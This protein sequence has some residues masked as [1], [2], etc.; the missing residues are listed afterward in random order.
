MVISN[1]FYTALQL[2]T[3]AHETERNTKWTF[4][5]ETTEKINVTPKAFTRRGVV[6]VKRLMSWR[7]GMHY[8]GRKW[9]VPLVIDHLVELLTSLKWL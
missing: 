3:K 9:M 5:E 2:K 8:V 1:S 6:Y 4:G 7:N